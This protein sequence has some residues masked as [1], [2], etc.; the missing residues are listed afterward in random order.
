MANT[1]ITIS[2]LVNTNAATVWEYYTNPIHVVNWNFASDDWHC[3]SASNNLC[4]GG[5]FC[6]RMEAKD[7]SWGFDFAAT[8]TE[9]TPQKS[10]TY[11]MDDGREVSVHLTADNN[12][13]RITVTFD[14]ETENPIEMQRE[15]WQAILNN[16][17]SY[18]ENA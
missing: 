9:V 4:I 12:A 18:T 5:T 10:Y 11:V 2:A 7:G 13:T 8:Y 6:A 3:P 1:K 15:G 16:F 17:K 14:A